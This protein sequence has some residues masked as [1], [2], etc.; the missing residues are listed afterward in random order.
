MAV[1]GKVVI[2]DFLE[3]GANAFVAGLAAAIALS[4]VTLLLTTTAQ[5]ATLNDAK[6]GQLLLRAG[7]PGE[8]V[9]A[10]TV[11]TEV[12]IQV[13]GIIART[14]LS[15]VFHNP[16]AEF[17]EGVYVFPLP[18]RAAVDHLWMRIGER[19]IEG[20]IQEKEEARKT[21]EKAKSEGKKAALVEQQRPNLLTNSVAH[22]GPNEQVR[23]TIE[24]Q[25]TLAYD[26]GE[27][28][29]RFPLAV[30]PRYVPASASRESMPDEPKAI[31]ALALDGPVQTPA[32]AV[33]TAG[34]LVNPVDIAVTIDAGVPIAGVVSSRQGGITYVD[35]SQH[36]PRI[37]F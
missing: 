16:G 15:Q 2:G 3:L 10:P 14:R 32:Y 4:V 34:A 6:T 8:Y 26:N 21:Y 20:V 36:A 19:A 29:L 9:V 35:Q 30:A 23:V 11:E 12:A 7:N 37:S 33:D 24:Y 1:K 22:I 31:E 13:T 27:Y 25:Q 18:E 17:V 5:A 28:R